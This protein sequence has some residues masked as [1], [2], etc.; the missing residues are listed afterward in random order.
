MQ[1]K[2]SMF[3]DFSDICSIA[4]F[5]ALQLVGHAT[6]YLSDNCHTISCHMSTTDI[7]IAT[8]I[9]RGYQQWDSIGLWYDSIRSALSDS[10]EV[11]SLASVSSPSGFEAGCGFWA[12]AAISDATASDQLPCADFRVLVQVSCVKDISRVNSCGHKFCCKPVSC[13]GNLSIHTYDISRK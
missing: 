13:F 10:S 11:L 1:T 7:T 9:P 3:D 4:Y 5:Y 12:S 8:R 6:W 2:T